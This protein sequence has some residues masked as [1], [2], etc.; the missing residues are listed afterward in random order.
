MPWFGP[1]VAAGN[2]A[3]FAVDTLAAGRELWVSDGSAAGTRMVIDGRPGA[4]GG[5]PEQLRPCPTAGW[6]FRSTTG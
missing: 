3:F 1:Q 6:S 2:K 5:A 4:A